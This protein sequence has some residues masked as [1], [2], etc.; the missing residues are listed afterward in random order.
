[1]PEEAMEAT[2]V[3]H[4]E[5]RTWPPPSLQILCFCQWPVLSLSL[6]LQ[7]LQGCP[8]R[9]RQTRLPPLHR[10]SSLFTGPAQGLRPYHIFFFFRKIGQAQ[11]FIKLYILIIV[12]FFNIFFI[13]D[14]KDIT[15]FII[16]LQ[17]DILPIIK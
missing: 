7:I 9:R 3:L 8:K 16:N 4:H 12:H 17:I 14:A 5:R 13:S 15:N 10:Y 1:M 11:N 2:H 6:S